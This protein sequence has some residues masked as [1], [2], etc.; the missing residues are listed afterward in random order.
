VVLD[1][2]TNV[3]DVVVLNP[4]ESKIVSFIVVFDIIE[5]PSVKPEDT[6]PDWDQEYVHERFPESY[7]ILNHGFV[8]N[9][10][11]ILDN[12]FESDTDPE[13]PIASAIL[14]DV[15]VEHTVVAV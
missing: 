7:V 1:L 3:V 8:K 5:A 2:F 13:A 11:F 15:N 6:N 9:V 12:N 4:F 14:W 10:P